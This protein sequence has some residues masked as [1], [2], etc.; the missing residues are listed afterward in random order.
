M[1]NMRN[2]FLIPISKQNFSIFQRVQEMHFGIPYNWNTGARTPV[3]I[4]PWMK[5]H[6]CRNINFT[7][8]ISAKRSQYCRKI[9][10]TQDFTWF[11][12]K[13]WQWNEKTFLANISGILTK[14]N[15]PNIGTIFYTNIGKYINTGWYS[16]SRN[17]GPTL[18][19]HYGNIQIFILLII[20][21]NS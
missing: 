3:I 2:A 7:L 17:V 14:C 10:F 6:Y 1:T 5:C 19:Y 16:Q 15:S 21:V 11:Y 4:K 8:K 9:G 20:I 13:Y 18:F 12:R